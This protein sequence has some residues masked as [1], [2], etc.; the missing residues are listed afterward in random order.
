LNPEKLIEAAKK[1][2]EA[3]DAL[4]TEFHIIN[5]TLAKLNIGIPFDFKIADGLILSYCKIEDHWQLGIINK[6]G[7]WALV[8]AP[9]HYRIQAANCLPNFL[10]AYESYVAKVSEE[11]ERA[12]LLAKSFVESIQKNK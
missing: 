9:R 7:Q 11:I 6:S 4:N 3:S 5:Q 12:K 1:L 2:N 10:E 8:S